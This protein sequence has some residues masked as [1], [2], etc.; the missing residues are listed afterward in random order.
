MTLDLTL[1]DPRWTSLPPLAERGI[2]ATLA[3]LGLDPEIC[4]ISL[5]G[6]D[7]SRIEALN[8]EYRDKPTPTNVLSWP[9]EDLSPKIAGERPSLPRP[10]FTGE[11]ALGDIAISF[12][13]CQREAEETGKTMSDHVTHLVI[14]GLLHLLGYDHVRDPDAIV[15]EA[16]ESEILGK[17]GID[18]PYM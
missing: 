14:H 3:H 8:T 9:A 16:L 2:S 6:C 12:D 13:T 17:L 4:E 1:E 11:I 18:D 7:D 5:L 10:D 15:M